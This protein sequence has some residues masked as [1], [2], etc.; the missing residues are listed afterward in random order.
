MFMSYK[1]VCSPRVI[2]PFHEHIQRTS[3]FKSLFREL[4]HPAGL[5]NL[6]PGRNS[7]KEN[8]LDVSHDNQLLQE[9]G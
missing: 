2:V 3:P 4:S 6:R 5:Y 1:P 8:T 9:I 7:L